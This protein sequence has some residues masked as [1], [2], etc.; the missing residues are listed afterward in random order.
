MRLVGS[1]CCG[2]CGATTLVMVALARLS[3]P[4]HCER[5]GGQHACEVGTWWQ[6]DLF[7]EFLALVQFGEACEALDVP[8]TA[9]LMRTDARES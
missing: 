9:G 4:T 2:C 1:E 3:G 6:A 8:L 7:E 5:C